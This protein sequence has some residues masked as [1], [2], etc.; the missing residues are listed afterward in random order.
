VHDLEPWYQIGPLRRRCGDA[1]WQQVLESAYM[2]QVQPLCLCRSQ[3]MAMYIARYHEFVVKRTAGTSTSPHVH[4]TSRR[5]TNPVWV[6]FSE[7]P[8]S[9]I[10]SIAS[11]SVS[12]RLAEADLENPP[13]TNAVHSTTLPASRAPDPS[14]LAD[15]VVAAGF[16][17]APVPVTCR[18]VMAE[19]AKLRAV[20]AEITAARSFTV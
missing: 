12:S 17:F 10:A 20:I 19:L 18:V 3:G 5:Q 7:K 13:S 1:D 11:K 14:A 9:S 15:G 4:R 16:H 8:Y 2:Q 6:K